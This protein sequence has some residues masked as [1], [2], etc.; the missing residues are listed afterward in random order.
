[1]KARALKPEDYI[2]AS[3]PYYEP[4]GPEMLAAIHVLGTFVF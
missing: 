1:M 4:S 2:L 3:Q